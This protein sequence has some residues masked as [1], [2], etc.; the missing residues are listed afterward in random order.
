LTIVHVNDRKEGSAGRRNNHVGDPAAVIATIVKRIQPPSS[1]DRENDPDAVAVHNHKRDNN[2]AG[3]RNSQDGG[4]PA[5]VI[6]TIVKRIQP[7]YSHDK[8]KNPAAVLG[9]GTPSWPCRRAQ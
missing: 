5:A 3:R 9:G 2:S 6:A 7:P 1:H 8:E 4:E